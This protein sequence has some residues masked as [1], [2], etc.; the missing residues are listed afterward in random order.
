M[1]TPTPPPAPRFTFEQLC[2]AEDR[3]Q[4]MRDP[5]QQ[6]RLAVQQAEGYRTYLSSL[7]GLLAAVFVLKGQEDLSKM[8]GCPRWAVISLLIGGF[9]GLIVATWLSV[10]ATDSRPGVE[11]YSEP[12]RLL[13]YEKKRTR[14]VWRL[15]EA[16]RWLG[17]ASVVAIAAA[18]VITWLAPTK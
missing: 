11:V 1:P 4:Q 16:A 3:A 12:N 10:L 18:V 8:S 14:T 13:T 15:V 2:D 6:L 9:A 17:L 5:H 7:T